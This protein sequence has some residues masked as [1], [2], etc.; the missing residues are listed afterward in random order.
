MKKIFFLIL[1]ALISFSAKSSHL[2][3][4]E[5]TWECLKS[6]PNVGKYIFTLK[7]YRDCSGI[8]VS[9]FAQTITVWGHP[10]ISSIT[11]D[12]VSQTDVSPDCDP[13]NSGNPQYNCANGNL[14][15]VEEYIFSSQPVQLTGSPAA[16]GW[17]F[18]W[19]SCCRNSAI[20]NLASASEGF[21]LRASMYPYLD[22][23]SG[24]QIPADPCFDSSPSFKEQPKTILC[25]GFPFSYSHNASD[26][27]LD[28]LVYSW[29]DP[30]DDDLLTGSPFNPQPVGTAGAN[31]SILAF[32]PPYTTISPLPGFPTIDAVTGE[33][34][35]DANTAGFFVT[36]VKVQAYKCGQLVAEIFREVQVVLV[37]CPTMPGTGAAN[38]PPSIDQPFTDPLTLL[39]SY[40]TTVYAGTLVNFNIT[41]TDLDQY[42]G[43]IDQQL[44]ME[45][46]GGQFS[47][48]FISTINCLNPPCA[49]FNNGAG[50]T[51][52]FSA[53]GI[54][55]G[56]FEW[57]TSCAHINAIQ[58]CGATTSTFTFLVKVHDDFCPAYGITI[59]TITVNVVPPIPDLRCI[60]VDDN[61]DIELTW[62]YAPGSPPTNE[63]YYVYHSSDSTQPFTLIDSVFHPDISYKHFG[64][65]GNS[66]SQHYF[67]ATDQ[68]CGITTGQLH[69][70]TLS[71]IFLDGSAID[72]GVTADL[73]WNTIHNPLLITSD[74]MYHLYYKKEITWDLIDSTNI[75]SYL[76]PADS[77]DYYPEF[78]V[79]ISDQTGCNSISSISTIHLL[80]TIAP[81]TPIISDVS[82]DNNDRS[83]LSW[84]PAAGAS[85]YVIYLQDQFG[86]WITIDSVTTTSFVYLSSNAGNTYETFRIRALDSCSNASATTLEHNSIN[87]KA[88]L[89]ACQH[90]IALDWND[91]I[92]WSNGLSHYTLVVNETDLNGLM[93]SNQYRID[94]EIS[95]LLEDIINNYTYEIYIL[96]YNGDS[97]YVAQSNKLT[98]IPQLPK[99]PD[100]NY[101]E[102]ATVNHDNG[103]VDIS[104]RVDNQGVIEKYLVY[105]SLRDITDFSI[106]GSV[107]FNGSSYISYTDQDASTDKSYYQYRIL[108]VD[109][110]G[111]IT[112]VGSVKDPITGISSSDTSF[113]QTIFLN[114]VINLD[115]AN[116]DPSLEGEYTNTIYFN[117][118]DKWLGE[119]SSYELYR[120]VN[121]EPFVPIPIH[122]FDSDDQLEFIDV[123]T[124]YGDGNGRFCYYIKAIEGDT[125]P[126]LLK[127]VS[128]SNISCVSQTPILFV[129]NTFTPNADRHNEVF[130][131]VSYFVS[132]DGYSF[133]IYNRNGLQIF[134]TDDPSKGWDGTYK[135]EVVQNGNYV[136]HLQYINGVGNL[137]EKR[138]MVTLI[139]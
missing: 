70:D 80:D 20:V 38:T 98:L 49:T 15:A 29:G 57:Q 69:S 103:Y 40:E 26:P 46:S 28:E 10:T 19:S 61:G 134:S 22:P 60:S 88:D 24:L 87:I 112:Y 12:F 18:T 65:N 81:S 44:T 90:T 136:Y 33:V 11:A 131:P 133:S 105:R 122:T 32:A 84:N 117:K 37:A 97:T 6:G 4:G 132:E 130:L 31:P 121:R 2:M 34:S 27:E 67:L 113:A 96:A 79:Q 23:S 106:I 68:S 102:Y 129:P 36:C 77:C 45:V 66:Q 104:C 111:V 71:S 50:I 116:D 54:V 126:Y 137:T 39:P 83:V 73:S 95:Y 21:C 91:Y 13:V 120:S 78:R 128:Y 107:D 115:Y 72:L 52:P 48:D 17:H 123:V 55:S 93:N 86:A 92:N 5:I 138:D 100:Y 7:V 118:Y 89:N 47:N 99:K 43:S 109:T 110:C 25:T 62:Q 59:A 127:E 64:A 119:V 1:V 114:S 74:T 85:L 108:P 51:P 9:T 53:P 94:S 139:R 82:V 125:N 58:G 14:G 124:E 35:Y 135:G 63:P 101:I 30:L 41:G 56:V 42:P 75:L 3:G 8:T 76:F 16:A